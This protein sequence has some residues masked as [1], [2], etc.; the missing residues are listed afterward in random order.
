MISSGVNLFIIP[1]RFSGNR[2]LTPFSSNHHLGKLNKDE[3]IYAK[4]ILSKKGF[5]VTSATLGGGDLWLLSAKER[6]EYIT[7]TCGEFEQVT[8]EIL[9]TQVFEP[10]NS[11][12]FVTYIYDFY[13]T[14]N[15][16]R[17]IFTLNQ[18]QNS[19]LVS[20]LTEPVLKYGFNNCIRLT[21]TISTANDIFFKKWIY[22]NPAS[23]NA[24]SRKIDKFITEMKHTFLKSSIKFKNNEPILCEQPKKEFYLLPGGAITKVHKNLLV[25]V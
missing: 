25:K 12:C 10:Q 19:H 21:S 4:N 23:F 6:K 17:E 3:I 24:S 7:T 15:K 13:N 8:V 5:K 20:Y 9:P 14:P 22:D 2:I 11:N 1:T 16:A 18:I